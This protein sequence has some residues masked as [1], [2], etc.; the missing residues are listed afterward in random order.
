MKIVISITIFCVVLF[1]YLHV[2][3]H[4]KKSND[5]DVY[6]LNIPSKEKLDDVADIRQPLTFNSSFIFSKLIEIFDLSNISTQFYMFDVNIGREKQNQV[7]LDLQKTMD[8]HKKDEI[9]SCYNEFFLE[10]TGLMKEIK[11][12]DAF[13]RPTGVCSK[14]YDMI[15]G[16]SGM[17]T[18]FQYKLFYRNYLLV[19][20]GSII[21]K[22]A[23]PKSISYLHVNKDY[24]NFVF[25]ANIDPWL[26]YKDKE[27][28]TQEERDFE[29]IKCLEVTLKKGDILYIPAYWFYSIQILER[30]SVIL[31]FNYRTY[32]NYL[33]MLPENMMHYLQ[34]GNTKYK[35]LQTKEDIERRE[36]E[37][38]IENKDNE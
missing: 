18:P 14:Q 37:N 13:L 11:R 15:F 16:S 30:E 19:T 27:D 9:V 28:K 2:L 33:A 10:Q 24:E 5:I 7:P 3:F 35:M 21:V 20:S 34:N 38:M 31:E 26:E 22:M 29:K 8:L 4:L 25:S 32:F 12:Y 6:H 23:S 36:N 1:L 17:K